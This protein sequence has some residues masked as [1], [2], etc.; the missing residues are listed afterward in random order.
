MILIARRRWGA[1][2]GAAFIAASTACR[3][4]AERAP[5]E[6][7]YTTR[8]LG[9]S[10]LQRNQLAE[11]ESSFKTITRLAPDDPAGFADLGLTYLQA[12]RYE[13][14]EKQLRRARELDPGSTEVALALA[15]LY[16]LTGRQSDARAVLERLRAD[17]TVN[18]RVLFAL[19]ELEAPR[20]DMPAARGY[21][22]RLRDVLAVAPAN[23]A[24]R[25]KL[26]D[27]LAR[28]GEADSVVRHLE[29][30]RRV[31]PAPPR[32]AKTHLDS[33]IQ[34]L[35]ARKLA[36]S[37]PVLDRFF[38][39]MEVTAPYQAS[40]DDVRW[41]QGPI[42]GRPVLTFAPKDFVALRK[43]RERATVDLARFTDATSE[44]GLPPGEPVSGDAAT[45]SQATLT[46]LAAGDVDGDGTSDLFVSLWSPQRQTSVARL[47]RVQ[48]GFVGDATERS[49]ISLPRGAAHATFADYD[50][51]GWLDLFVIGGD[52]RGH[53]FRNRGNGTFVDVSAAARVSDVRG[54]RKGLFVDLDHDGDLDLL[55]IA[56]AQRTVYR[57]NL[58]GTFTDAT[59]SFALAG[60]GD[61]RDAVFGD[62]DGD[63]RVDIF[64]A[65]ATGS[66]VLLRN[67]SPQRLTD[68]TPAS[69]L[70][71]SSGSGAAAAGD[72]NNDGSLDLFVAGANG[73]ESQLWLN[74]G[75]ASFT[76]DTRSSQAMQGLRFTAGLA[77][78]FIDY[79]NDGWL[80]LLVAG[81][82]V[83]RSNS[84]AGVVLLRNDRTGR[85][86]DRSA[87]VPNPVRAA[88][89]TG[90]AL[91]DVDD[92]GDQDLLLIDATGSPRLLRNDFGN[93]N[94]AVKVELKALRTGSGKNNA[95]GIGA[96]LELRAGQIYQTRVVT[97]PVTHFGLGPHL[98]ADVLRVEW[99]NG[100]PQT[101]YFP[102]SDQDVVES[103]MLK[104]SCALAYTWDGKRFRF[105]T[106]AMWRS[107]LGMPLGLMAGGGGSAYAPAGA[108]QEYLRIPGDALQPRDGRYV[109]QLTEELWETAYAD[110]VK[111]LTVDHPDSV[112]VFVDE[113]F[114]PPG[115]VKLRLFQVGK[116]DLPRSAI[117]D[118]GDDVLPALR[119]TD[120]VYVSNLTPT[121]YQ[122]VVE[123]HDL[124]MDLGDA[125]GG[126]GTFLFLRGW[127]YPTDASINVA[128]AQQSAIKLASPSLE[129]RD[130]SGRWRTV[131]AD[132][133]FPSGK[134]KTVVID[135]AGKFPT[136]DHR[137]RIR[138]NMQIYW[139]QAF[140]AR[141]LTDAPAK[142]TT[143]TPVSADLHFRGFSRMYRKGG[144]YGPYWFAYDEV[145]KESP[146]RP[147]E[148]AFTRFGN[149]LPLLKDPDDMYVI[150][151][152]GDEATIEFDA[153]SAKS[154]PRGWRRDFLLYTDGWIKDSD[155]NTAFGTT[156]NP[157]PYHGVRAY[158]FGPA[159]AY[160]TDQRRQR[161]LREYNTRVVKRR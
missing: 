149:V 18:A 42:P 68:V 37:R 45:G 144:R 108:S 79:D 15:K 51:D 117:D 98:K 7:L 135:L 19:A 151:G 65:S 34:L 155:L 97:G 52:A 129:V 133:G 118:R 96:R 62:F 33:A 12:G 110:E 88:G 30:V 6:E 10:Y 156:V 3:P 70:A 128:L 94:L 47:Y 136:A 131:I 103:E 114:V 109:L 146:W 145:T 105:V 102:G 69:G 11:A 75:N 2:I 104:G 143:L 93:S 40:L 72:Y 80:D 106:D 124:I 83:A 78:A 46:A 99:P 122:G 134:D 123:P 107:A 44:V 48:G 17:T 28:R 53:L 74:K 89:A 29:E 14:A 67:G 112:D 139:D 157:L 35:R 21:E 87:V 8:M 142:V 141:A 63:G 36:E 130:A 137:V 115:P 140:V 126:A 95:F 60:G 61:A 4:E 5:V 9:L 27:A 49:G 150:M 41:T 160:P 125:A 20:G 26:V 119:E 39:S 1:I 86:V 154:L 132:I 92:D 84:P 66:N 24:A 58:D 138:T 111:L 90:I 56:S 55:L 116:R 85:F 64:I 152:P 91:S 16:A 25:L 159:D 127:I 161:Y 57:N 23:L 50:N 153:S 100:V 147:I 71:G 120:D 113:R 38:R 101:V 76:R 73:S 32:E 13:D 82:P 77:T 22:R 81:T 158:P 43:V 54:A 148:G 59:S 121:Q 31:P